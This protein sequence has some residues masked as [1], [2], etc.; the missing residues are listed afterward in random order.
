[1]EGDLKLLYVQKFKGFLND[2]LENCLML[3]EA[4]RNKCF[5]AEEECW[6][7]KIRAI[8]IKSGDNNTKKIHRFASYR[9]NKKHL[10]DIT[11]E[12]DRVHSGQ[13][14]IND[15][16]ISYFKYFFQDTSQFNLCD[17]MDIVRLYPNLVLEDEV[18]TLENPRTLEE[19]SY[20]FKGFP[21]DKVQAL[22]G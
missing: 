7:K 21:K 6:R 19:I 2:D 9:R 8:W 20:V 10:W 13:D 3:L 22:M 18:I 17:Q 5:L 4:E 1:M 11:D 15:E 14:A 12:D 16:A